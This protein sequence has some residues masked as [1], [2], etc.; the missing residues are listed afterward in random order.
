MLLWS[1]IILVLV[2]MLHVSAL[3]HLIVAPLCNWY[4]L[5][6]VNL[7]QIID[8]MKKHPQDLPAFITWIT[9]YGEHVAKDQSARQDILDEVNG[10]RQLHDVFKR[11]EADTS[12]SMLGTAK[13]CSM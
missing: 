6:Q 2:R 10:I 11:Y 3:L 8:G 12:K 13:V 9:N 5:F 4:V 7:A 1:T